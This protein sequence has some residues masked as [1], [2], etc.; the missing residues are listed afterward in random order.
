MK[1][2]AFLNVACSVFS[3]WKNNAFNNDAKQG[4]R[5]VT[6]E[7]LWWSGQHTVAA[8]S[9]FYTLI[10]QISLQAWMWSWDPAAIAQRFLRQE[11]QKIRPSSK[12]VGMWAIARCTHDLWDE[13]LSFHLS[14]RLDES[15]PERLLSNKANKDWKEDVRFNLR[16][17]TTPSY[18]K[19]D[20]WA[21]YEPLPL[22]HSDICKRHINLWPNTTYGQQ[23]L[24][25]FAAWSKHAP[26]PWA[27]VNQHLM[28]DIC[29]KF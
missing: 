20:M 27:K 15:A 24:A 4:T 10:W 25:H 26:L 17:R 9:C 29:Q 14:T 2:F 3:L 22:L 11:R 16:V 12:P 8:F 5:V 21:T 18:F 28:N 23:A 6:G 7:L 1:T 19:R 13:G